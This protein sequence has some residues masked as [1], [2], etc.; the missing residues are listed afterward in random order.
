VD[1]RSARGVTAL[2]LACEHGH[3]PAVELLLKRGAVI[4]AQADVCFAL[5][6]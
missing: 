2:G 5:F 1:H 4:N 3:R 6:L